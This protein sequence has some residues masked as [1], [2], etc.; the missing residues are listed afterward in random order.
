M[1]L[2]TF[3]HFSVYPCVDLDYCTTV[4]LSTCLSRSSHGTLREGI[5]NIRV[6]SGH[7]YI[8]SYVRYSS[9]KQMISLHLESFAVYF[10]FLLFLL[11]SLFLRLERS[12]SQNCTA[13]GSQSFEKTIRTHSKVQLP[14]PR[15]KSVSRLSIGNPCFH[16]PDPAR[17]RTPSRNRH[18]ESIPQGEPLPPYQRIAYCTLGEKPSFPSI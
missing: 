6:P 9:I 5:T 17:G 13:I 2:A 14:L 7:S 3:Y 16:P 18:F 10:L 4:L 8:I 1:P 11:A 12:L 15:R